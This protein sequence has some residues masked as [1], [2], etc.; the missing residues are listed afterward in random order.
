MNND[1]DATANQEPNPR[2]IGSSESPPNISP[3][4]TS[5]EIATTPKRKPSKTVIGGIIA[6]ALVLLGGGAALGYTMWYQNPDKVVHDAIINTIKAEAVTM[7]GTVN[8]TSEDVA[9]KLDFDS[10]SSEAGDGEFSVK[11]NITFDDEGTDRDINVDGVGRM[12]EDT[13]YFKVGGIKEI[14]DEFAE[15]EGSPVPAFASNIIDKVDNKWISIDPSDYSD[16]SEE[17]SEQQ[18]C[19]TNL[20]KKIQSDK[21]MKDQVIDLYRDNQIVTLKEEL[22]SKSV[23]GIGSLGYEIDLDQDAAVAFTRGL[24]DTDLGKELKVC[25]ENIDF[26]QLADDIANAGGEETSSEV[27]GKVELWVSRFG[28]QIT[29]LNVQATG[30]GNESVSVFL[31]PTFNT[32]TNVEAPEDAISLKELLEDLQQSFM[33][34]FMNENAMMESNFELST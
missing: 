34:Q 22:G 11:A 10:K 21:G 33:D 17:V 5:T 29:E 30:D 18:E 7:A 9:F 1:P 8:F 16:I 19:T 23:N 27:D 2:P 25:N 31:H 3:P 26:D 6:G 15:S 32:T 28:H 4:V 14:F 13:L 20:M 24:K 12:V